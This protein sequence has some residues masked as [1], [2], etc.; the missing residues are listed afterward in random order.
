M[1]KKEKFIYWFIGLG[2]GIMLSGIIITFI[3]LNLKTIENPN[4]NQQK[5]VDDL[6]NESIMEKPITEDKERQEV[7][8]VEQ[9]V[10]ESAY[11]WVDIPSAYSATQI[12]YFLETEGIV[13]DGVAFR[14]YIAEQKK[15]TKLRTGNQ[16]L[17]MNGEYDEILNI[18]TAQ[19]SN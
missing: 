14:N 2:C 4:I 13:D 7:S 12:S 9:E 5:I 19:P 16:Y 1:K 11:K 18:L 3:G 15:T 8:E 17:P 10:R 6:P